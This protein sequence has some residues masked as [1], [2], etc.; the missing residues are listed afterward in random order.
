ML[1]APQGGSGLV[2]NPSGFPPKRALEG[3]ALGGGETLAPLEVSNMLS[4]APAALR[5]GCRLKISPAQKLVL[6]TPYPADLFI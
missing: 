4:S 6:A 2:R 5:L 3:A 1:S